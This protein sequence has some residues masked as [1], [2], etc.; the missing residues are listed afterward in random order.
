MD[1]QALIEEL[2]SSNH[3][4]AYRSLKLLETESEHSN[5]IY[6]HF[7]TF[8]KMLRHE[9]SYIRTRGII[10]ISA[11]AKWDVDFKID[12]II[13]LLLK[14]VEDDKSITARQCIK[15]LPRIAMY[16]ADLKND[17]IVALRK[18]H[19]KMYSDSMQPLIHKDIALAIKQIETMPD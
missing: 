5:E 14:S 16:K 2:Y 8:V 11:N 19:T 3:K 7:D 10:L 1:V 13:D 15:N 6:R 17:I 18:A 12:E 9:N 4:T